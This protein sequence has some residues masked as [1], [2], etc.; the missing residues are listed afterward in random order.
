MSDHLV[1]LRSLSPTNPRLCF[2]AVSDHLVLLQAAGRHRFDERFRV[3]SNHLILLHTRLFR[4]L[5]VSEPCQITWYFYSADGGKREEGV[6]EPCRITWFSY[7]A[8][9][10][11]AGEQFQS[12]VR[13]VDSLT[14]SPSAAGR[15]PFQSRVRSPGS[16]A[17]RE[18]GSPR[19][20]FRAEPNHLVLLPHRPWY[21]GEL[22]SGP[23]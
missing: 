1:L 2:R 4:Y 19:S 23:C 6:L 12:R 11:R 7:V 22:V 5:V 3:V 18:Y 17:Q 15:M 20:G 14:H 13:S 10:S 8:V 9:V 21:I 16:L